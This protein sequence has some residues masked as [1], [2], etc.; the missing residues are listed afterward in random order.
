MHPG[1]NTSGREESGLRV[2][3]LTAAYA[4]QA[5]RLKEIAFSA[6]RGAL[7]GVLGPNGSGKSTLIMALAG[8][9]PV[10]GGSIFWMGQNIDGLRPRLRAGIMAALPQ[11]SMDLPDMTVLDIVLMGRYARSAS[12]FGYAEED[13]VR[14]VSALQQTNC[15]GLIHKRVRAVSGGEL[16]RVLLA[17]ALAQNCPVLLLDEPASS[18]DPGQ[19]PAMLA[20]LRRLAAQEQLCVILALHDLN[21]AALYCDYLVLLKNGRIFTQGITGQVFTQSILEQVYDAPFTMADHPSGFKQALY[22]RL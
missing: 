12:W 5:F 2:A 7:V 1:A 3:G 18:L 4:G 10:L 16:Q 13:E 11:K 19:G 22:T 8:L 21:L 14:A 17:R 9:V 15:A 20:L 6:E